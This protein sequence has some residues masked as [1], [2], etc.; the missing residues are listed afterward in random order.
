MLLP[1]ATEAML[2]WIWAGMERHISGQA[3]RAKMAPTTDTLTKIS[4]RNQT[5]LFQDETNYG[6]AFDH[7]WQIRANPTQN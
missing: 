4:C 1:K 5:I 2:M 6:K 3:L 7:L